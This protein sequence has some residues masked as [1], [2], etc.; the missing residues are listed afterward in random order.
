MEKKIKKYA[1]IR[2]HKNLDKLFTKIVYIFQTSLSKCIKILHLD[3][4]FG[5]ENPGIKLMIDY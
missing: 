5:I 3:T 4:F 1:A 2:P